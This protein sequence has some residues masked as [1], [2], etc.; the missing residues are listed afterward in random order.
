MH[1]R[2]TLVAGPSN[3]LWMTGFLDVVYG[4]DTIDVVAIAPDAPSMLKL[5]ETH[6]PDMV[7]VSAR[8]GERTQ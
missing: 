2:N 3:P 8:L 6:K 7:I 5:V 1:N 4:L